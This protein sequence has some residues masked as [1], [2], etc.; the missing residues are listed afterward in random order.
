[1]NKL[2][3]FLEL[4]KREL[5]KFFIREKWLYIILGTIICIGLIILGIDWAGRNGHEEIMEIILC[6]F[7]GIGWTIFIGCSLYV[8]V[9]SNLEKVNRYFRKTQT[10]R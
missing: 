2:R 8:W 7:V 3:I 1:M 5:W 10:K 9:I 4:K 6:V